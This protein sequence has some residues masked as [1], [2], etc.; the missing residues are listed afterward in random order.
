LPINNKS[1]LI[2]FQKAVDLGG[3]A[4]MLVSAPKSQSI[5]EESVVSLVSIAK[6]YFGEILLL[7]VAGKIKRFH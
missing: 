2:E 1:V 7:C 6:S 4:K 3:S 5:L